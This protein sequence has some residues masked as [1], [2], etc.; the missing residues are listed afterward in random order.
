MPSADD[1]MIWSSTTTAAVGG[2]M[3]VA[4][5]VLLVID[6]L[7]ERFVWLKP[8]TNALGTF[9]GGRKERYAE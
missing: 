9:L 6:A 5:L 2:L 4:R 7:D 3:A 8:L 1:M